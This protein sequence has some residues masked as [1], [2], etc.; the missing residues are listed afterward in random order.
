MLWGEFFFGRM[1]IVIVIVIVIVVEAKDRF[2]FYDGDCQPNDP[3]LPQLMLWSKFFTGR[4]RF[5]TRRARCWALQEY[6]WA[7]AAYCGGPQR[8]GGIQGLATHEQ[9]LF[10]SW[11]SVGV[12][13]E[14]SQVA[15]VIACEGDNDLVGC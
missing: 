10:S 11:A 9:G 1:A 8:A 7:A 14:R 13:D 5:H 15:V 2:S 3:L 12:P 6:N 4:L